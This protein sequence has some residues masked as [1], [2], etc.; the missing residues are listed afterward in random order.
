MKPISQWKEKWKS[1]TSKGSVLS[2]IGVAFVVFAM[3]VAVYFVAHYVADSYSKDNMLTNWDYLYTDKA[4]A[5]PSGEMR[6][7]NTQNPFVTEKG[8]VKKNLYLTKMIPAEDSGKIFSMV[9]DFSPVKIRLNGKEIYNNHFDRDSYV[10]NCYNAV[11]IPASTHEQQLEVFMRLPLSVRFE[12]Y[13]DEGGDPAFAPNFAFW[14]GCGMTVVGVLALLVFAVMSIVRRR[15]LRTLMVAGIFALSG[16]AIV[17]HILPEITYR[18]NDPIWLK[19]TLLPV[20]LI[21]PATLACLNSMFKD[22]KRTLIAVAFA[23]GVSIIA[24]MAAMTPLLIKIATVAMDLL[25]LAASVFAAKLT[26]AHLERRTQYAVPVFVMNVYCALML[27]ASGLLLYARFRALYLYSV[28]VP[29]LVIAAVMEY[30][31]ITDYRYSRKNR[32]LRDQTSH[33]GDTVDNISVLIR[34]M[35]RC[36]NENHFY[37]KAVDEIILLLQKYNP[38]DSDVRS[39]AAKKTPGGFAEKVNRG[40]GDCDY[41]IIEKICLHNEK[42][43]LF[44]ETYFDFALR[45]GD[46]IG[47]VFHFENIRDGMDMFFISVLEATYCGLETAHENVVKHHTQHEINIIFEELAENAELDNGCSV[48][49]LQNICTYTYDLCLALGVDEE[50]AQHISVASKLHDLGKIAVPKYII[51]KEGRLNEEERVIVDSH[52][53]FGYTILSAYDDDPLIATAATIARYHHEHFD[54]TGINALKGED[55]PLEAR[56]VTVCD[57]YDALTMERTYKRAWSQK[58]ALHYLEDNK[59]KL[60][61]PKI[62]DAFIRVCEKAA[63]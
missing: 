22:H 23:T 49:H 61:D 28:I 54:G 15:R 27:L 47:A 13:L 34:N 10:G 4:G 6:V 26:A 37:E 29:A 58:D 35:L 12:A 7:Y 45:D 41:A 30:I 63:P 60:F 48:E 3:T 36:E 1:K 56:V 17:I 16:L 59:G 50:R 52:T 42:N 18:L 32:E 55:I 38:D 53:K 19:L 5:V 20:N 9:T 33:Y 43:C 62:T 44:A 31:F 40:V 14:F 11:E 51:H 2:L 57:V 39:C 21:F 46:E 8:A 24:V 25:C